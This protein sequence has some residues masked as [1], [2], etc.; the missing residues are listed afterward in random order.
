MPLAV[1]KQNFRVLVIPE[2]AK[3]LETVLRSVK[4][5]LNLSEKHIT[6]TLKDAGRSAKFIP[7]EITDSLKWEDVAKIEVNLP[8][9]PGVSIDENQRR[10]P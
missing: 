4:K 5:M 1:N 7:V 3:D 10:W 8:D 6:E 9:L 2:Q